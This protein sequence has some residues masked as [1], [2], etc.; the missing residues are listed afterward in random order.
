[1][2]PGA[3]LMPAPGLAAGWLSFFPWQKTVR[4]VRSSILLGSDGPLT[5]P[6]SYDGVPGHLYPGDGV[7]APALQADLNAPVP[8]GF[9]TEFLL[10]LLYL[11]DRAAPWGTVYLTTT[12]W[13][14]TKTPPHWAGMEPVTKAE[15]G[16]VIDHL[17]D[18]GFFDRATVL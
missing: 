11:D 17:A 1:M 7:E 18:D 15:A 5:F 12:V 9:A 6:V 2:E 14:M 16:R 13:E 3:S 4:Q 10:S 8:P